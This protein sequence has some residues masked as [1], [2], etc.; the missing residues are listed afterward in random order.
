MERYICES[1]NAH[2]IYDWITNRGGILIWN[3]IDL[4]DPS[5]SMTTPYRSENGEIKTKPHW[6]YDNIPSRHIT[7]IE[8]VSVSIP[9]EYKR[10]HVATRMGGNG[11]SLKVTDA[12]SRRIEKEVE[13]AQRETGKSSYYVFDYF[14]YEN[15]LIMVDDKIISLGEFVYSLKE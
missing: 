10:F 11:M 2:L 7:S 1:E 9:K 14:N 12:G 13:K 8:D 3:S 5:A 4:S 15:C 6:K